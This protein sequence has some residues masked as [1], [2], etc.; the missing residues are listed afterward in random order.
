MRRRRFGT[1]LGGIKVSWR[2][3]V[4][5]PMFVIGAVTAIAVVG[6]TGGDAIFWGGVLVAAVGAGIFVSG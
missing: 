1:P 4:G 3:E 6:V 2:W 5:L